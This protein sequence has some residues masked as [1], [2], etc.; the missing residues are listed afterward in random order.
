MIGL[1]KKLSTLAMT[2]LVD[3]KTLNQSLASFLRVSLPT[4]SIQDIKQAT[5][6]SLCHLVVS[7]NFDKANAAKASSNFA[8]AEEHYTSIINLA[9]SAKSLFTED[10]AL[11]KLTADAYVQRG[12]LRRG[13]EAL[14][15]FQK[16]KELD[17]ENSKGEARREAIL[18]GK[19]TLDGTRFKGYTIEFDDTPEL[20]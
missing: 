1:G 11:Q 2:N 5:I 9:E 7:T 14:E 19:G 6:P 12:M 8:E 16:A 10:T 20:K 13:S 4:F 18:I 15:D 17:P 3:Y